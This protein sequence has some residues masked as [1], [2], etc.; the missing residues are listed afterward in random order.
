MGRRVSVQTLSILSQLLPGEPREEQRGEENLSILSQLLPAHP[1]AGPAWPQPFN[2]F[3][4]AAQGGSWTCGM[5]ARFCSLSIL[6]QLL[7]RY[8]ST[9]GGFCVCAAFQFFP[10]CCLRLQRRHVPDVEHELS[11][12][13]QLLQPSQR[14]KE[15]AV[16]SAFQFF[17]GCCL[18]E[19]AERF[20]DIL[21][22]QFFPSC[23]RCGGARTPRGRCPFQFFPSCCFRGAEGGA[24]SARAFNSF[25]VA[26]V[27]F[28]NL[29]PH[30]VV[31]YAFQFFPSCCLSGLQLVSKGRVTSFNSFP[32]AAMGI[33][34]LSWTHKCVC[35]QFFPSCCGTTSEKP[36][37]LHISLSILSQLLQARRDPPR[38]GGAAE[39]FQFFP[40][41]CKTL[42]ISS[43]LVLK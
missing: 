11:I 5:A 30:E 25:P 7:L 33:L 39:G 13:S 28:V 21:N 1:S 9:V 31:V 22:F 27:N 20:E 23:C 18:Q 24:T 3:P 26:A 36:P 41:C 35:F 16:H 14:D 19:V 29:T 42:P 43:K 10:S 32:V 38:R 12:L 2:S 40:S 4:V 6:S 34:W 17:P 15:R 37:L 8:S